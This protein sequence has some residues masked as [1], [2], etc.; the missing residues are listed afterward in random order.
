MQVKNN[1]WIIIATILLGVMLTI[2]PMPLVFEGFRPDWALLIIIYWSLALPHR[3][4]IGIAWVTGFLLDVLLGSVL[5]I[6][7]AVFAVIVYISAVNY[8]KIRNFSLWQQ[9]LITGVLVALYHLLW[10]WLQHFLTDITFNISYLYP[11]FT[12]ILVW[13]WAFLLLRK[14]R[15]QFQVK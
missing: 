4:N 8:Q 6:N 7:A 11:A 10:F 14:V 3:A 9:A 1:G 15:R 2:M 5:G 13:P 12:A